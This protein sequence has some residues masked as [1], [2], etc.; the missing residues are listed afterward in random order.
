MQYIE[1]TCNF[2]N[3]H[4]TLKEYREVFNCRDSLDPTMAACENCLISH[5][6]ENREVNDLVSNID[7]FTATSTSSNV[8]FEIR[9]NIKIKE[10]QII[11]RHSSFNA[12][13]WA[14]GKPC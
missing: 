8:E 1:V 5:S 11:Y 7:I 13:F 10:I 3:L 9:S 6:Y 4:L 14:W 12:V 2:E